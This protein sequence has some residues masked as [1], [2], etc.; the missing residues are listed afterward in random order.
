LLLAGCRTSGTRFSPSRG[1][2]GNT[3]T[4]LQPE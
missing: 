3:A 4:V 2:A 1:L